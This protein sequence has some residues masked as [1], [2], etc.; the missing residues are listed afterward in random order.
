MADPISDYNNL[1]SQLNNNNNDDD[2]DDDHDIIETNDGIIQFYDHYNEESAGE[3]D[4]DDDDDDDVS[5]DPTNTDYN[6]KNDMDDIDEEDNDVVFNATNANNEITPIKTEYESIA[7]DKSVE[8]D[9]DNNSQLRCVHD[10]PLPDFPTDIDKQIFSPETIQ[11]MLVEITDE[12]EMREFG[13]IDGFYFKEQFETLDEMIKTVKQ[14]ASENFFIVHV[15]KHGIKDPNTNKILMYN[16]GN[17]NC[18]YCDPAIIF[19]GRKRPTC[20]WRLTFCY[21]IESDLYEFSKHNLQ[22]NHSITTKPRY[23][24]KQ[25]ANTPKIKTKF[26]HIT[27]EE[28]IIIHKFCNE[29]MYY[30]RT[31]LSKSFPGHLYSDKL[32][33]NYIHKLRSLRSRDNPINKLLDYGTKLNSNGGLFVTRVDSD[34]RV[35]HIVIQTATQKLFQEEYGDFFVIDG[36]HGTNIHGMILILPCVVDCLGKTKP[37]G[38]I[39]CKSESFE[40][41]HL[42]FRLLNLGKRNN[43]KFVNQIK[44]PKITIMTDGAEGFA[45]ACRSLGFNHVLCTYHFMRHINTTTGGMNNNLQKYYV[46]L[47][48]DLLFGSFNKQDFETKYYEL[49]ATIKNF[50]VALKFVETLYKHREKVAFSYV[51]KLFTAGCRAS[52]RGESIFCLLKH[53]SK[54]YCKD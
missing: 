40:D 4:D 39:L 23:Q 28:Q 33:H 54:K 22:H 29:D 27:D 45:K 46:K 52:Q 47:Y 16:R 20:K 15:Q 9:S 3:Y 34:N 44:R 8:S 19:S 30:I 18:Q 31:L 17:F 14:Y 42:G 6:L 32:L 50:D 53:N 11:N 41:I 37:I 24:H 26:E 48:N 2:A 38:T 36:T 5:I 12:H 43:T 35:N 7:S 51:A 13:I 25:I 49:R 21:N 10:N 1:I